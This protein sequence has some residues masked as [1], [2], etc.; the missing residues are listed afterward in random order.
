MGLRLSA[1]A[2]VWGLVALLILARLAAARWI[3]LTEDEAYYRLWSQ[4]LAF[5]Y[6][7]HPPMIAWWIRAG[8]ALAGD[9]PLG[10]R[11]MSVLATGLETLLVADLARRLFDAG[12]TG[13]APGQGRDVG[14]RAAVWFNATLTIG[15][16]GL[17][18]APDAPAALFWLVTVWSLGRLATGGSGAWWLLAGTASGLAALSKYSGFFLAPGVL[19]WVLV[20]PGVRA[21]LRTPWPWI[22]AVAGLAVFSPNLAWNSGHGWMT[23]AKQFGRIGSG[24]FSPGHLPEMLITQFVLLNPLVAIFALAG[25]GLAWSRRAEARWAGLALPLLTGA[26]FI[27]YLMA[28]ALQATVQGHWPVPLFAPLAVC[29]AV[30]AQARPPG[31]TALF[32][33]RAGAVAGLV[34]TSGA[35]WYMT[36]TQSRAFGTFDPILALRGWR[37][38]GLTV[39]D[40]RRAAGADWVGTIGYGTLS[41][42]QGERLIAAP[43]VQILERVRYRSMAGTAERLGPRGLIV[44]LA[45][46][47]KP[48]E[49]E[50]C[51]GKVVYLG[52]VDRGLKSGEGPAA[53][54]ALYRVEQARFDILSQGCPESADR[55]KRRFRSGG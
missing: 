1:R 43:T 31:P 12:P 50:R 51:F 44:D 5:G 49:L 27:A 46:R 14:L 25:A 21:M 11:L 8:V 15:I 36:Q 39:E 32:W 13:D 10:V 48:R 33:R 20:T 41:Q 28:H 23:F 17:L 22:A 34:L 24:A 37:E 52:D 29:A 19:L 3:H 9:N 26:P 45:R 38:F 6:Y 4:H 35:L 7:D 30:A 16:G 42:L 18:A 55:V 53:R 47:V 2:R 40:R 54:Y